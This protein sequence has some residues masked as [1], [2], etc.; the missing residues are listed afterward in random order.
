MRKA[1][2]AGKFIRICEMPDA[3][4]LIATEVVERPKLRMFNNL[5]T[6]MG[7]YT[8]IQ[9]LIARHKGYYYYQS[10]DWRGECKHYRTS[11]LPGYLGVVIGIPLLINRGGKVEVERPFKSTRAF[12]AKIELI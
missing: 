6:L 4:L 1:I 10:K 11:S 7:D 5:V 9:T 3:D 2:S 8:L 12:S